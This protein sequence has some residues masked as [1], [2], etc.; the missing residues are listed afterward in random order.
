MEAVWKKYHTEIIITALMIVVG[1]SMHFVC[2][3]VQNEKVMNVLG[4]IF[5]VSETSWEHM[6]MLWYPFLTVGIVLSITKKNP[7]YFGGFVFSGILAMLELLG[8]FFHLL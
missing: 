1:S 8:K 2:Y 3:L 4:I 6:K 7:G 5:P